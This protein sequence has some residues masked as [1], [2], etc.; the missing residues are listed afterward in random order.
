MQSALKPL[1]ALRA[2]WPTNLLVGVAVLAIGFAYSSLFTLGERF[3][4]AVG[5]EYWLFRPTDNAPLVILVLSAWLFYRR[6]YR[7][8]SMPR[9]AAHPVWIASSV[10]AAVAVH[11]WAVYTRAYDLEI[12]SLVFGMSALVLASWGRA[13]LRALWLPLLFLLFAIPMPAPLLL[14]IVFKLQIWTAQFAGLLLYSIG[15]PVLV[16]GDQII[17]ATQT[18]QVI[19]GCSGMRSIE[20]LTMLSILMVDL[21]GRRGWHAAVLVLAA[22]L[23]AFFLNGFRVL[24]LILNPHSEIIAIH[25]LQGIAI[26][27]V[28]L[29]LI[30]ALDMAIERLRGGE[31]QPAWEIDDRPARG[32]ATNLWLGCALGALAIGTL[33][34]ALL[35]PSWTEPARQSARVLNA[36]AP[37]LVEWTATDVEADFIYQGSVR[38]GEVVHRTYALDEAPVGVFVGLADLGQRGGSPISPLTARPGTGW[39]EVEHGL[40]SLPGLEQPVE[41]IEYSKG[42]QR[43]LVYH[44]YEGH[45]GL[46]AESLRSLAALDRSP[47]Q[48]TRPLYVVRLETPIT[49][50]RA[51]D[52]ESAA[53]RLVTVYDRLAPALER[54]QAPEGAG[55]TQ[56]G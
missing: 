39:M 25:N 16:S 13:G 21:F 29:L 35:V 26:L 8:Q 28:G 1:A 6:W 51:G 34:S 7:V 38:F 11:A 30:Y 5:V 17:R 24:T 56:S 33:S 10:G 50:H 46:A 45:M 36:V 47:L 37:Q 44:W 55:L 42:K 3:G 18:F 2:G 27:L 43:K 23:V 49:G 9:G 54:L 41:F 53:A 12:V 4:F 32:S 52:R 15:I 20:T 40:V 19:E 22:P 48:R 31:Q 14:A